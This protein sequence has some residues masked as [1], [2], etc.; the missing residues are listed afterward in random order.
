MTNNRIHFNAG[1]VLLSNFE[2]I[3]SVLLKAQIPVKTFRISF[4]ASSYCIWSA[5]FMLALA[6]PVISLSMIEDISLCH[7]FCVEGK[8]L[9][10]I[11]FRLRSFRFFALNFGKRFRKKDK[12]ESTSDL[13]RMPAFRGI[14]YLIK[15][16][17]LK[18]EPSL[19]RFYSAA[20][21]N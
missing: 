2:M 3:S 9:S 1:F 20:Y 7:S 15:F 14:W 18:H 16:I 13:K 10:Q 12:S 17:D 8:P 19:L 11:I 6:R 21:H 5:I 4:L